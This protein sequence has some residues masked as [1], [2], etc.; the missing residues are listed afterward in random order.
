[1]GFRAGADTTLLALCSL[2]L[3]LPVGISCGGVGGLMFSGFRDKGHG[4]IGGMYLLLC[5]QS[6]LWS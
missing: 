3:L 4:S 2:P 6:L 5:L 1:M